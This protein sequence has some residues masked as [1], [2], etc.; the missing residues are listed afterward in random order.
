MNQKGQ[1][2][3]EYVL[4]LAVLVAGVWVTKTAF[5]PLWPKFVEGLGLYSIYTDSFEI[6]LSLPFP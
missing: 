1:A 3:A 2:L 5:G 6:V 4:I